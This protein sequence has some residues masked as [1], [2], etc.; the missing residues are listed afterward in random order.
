MSRKWVKMTHSDRLY[1]CDTRTSSVDYQ[2]FTH[3]SLDGIAD[4]VHALWLEHSVPAV[5]SAQGRLG[6][7]EIK[8]NLS[9]NEK[10]EYE[11]INSLEST[12][13]LGAH[14]VAVG[15]HPDSVPARQFDTGR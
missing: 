4:A 8:I 14:V 10:G 2:R 9:A 3:V 1:Q 7:G 11:Y 12:A 5:S 6:W 15:L 13:R